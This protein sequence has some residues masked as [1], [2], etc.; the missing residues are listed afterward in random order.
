MKTITKIFA[1]LVLFLSCGKEASSVELKDG[2]V[3]MSDINSSIIF[4]MRYYSSHNF[5]G[6]TIDGYECAECILTT[7][8]AMA[9]DAIQ[10]ELLPFGLT[11]KIYDCYRPQRAVDHFV[12]WAK[13]LND[14]KMKKEFYP[15]VDKSNLFKDGYI[16][17]KSSHSR[18]STVD[19][20]IV[21]IPVPEQ[22]EYIDGMELVECYKPYDIRFGDNTIDMGTGFDCFGDYSHPVN[23]EQD[24][25]VRINRLLLRTL[26]LKHGFVPY[27]FEWWHFTYKNEPYPDTY[28]DFPVSR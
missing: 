11:L 5:I 14:D 10:K 24:L 16:A 18:G 23:A 8:A 13:D 22:E 7:E 3:Y 9:V 12:R 26:M 2:F 25:Q 27:E 4:D 1:L 28:F 21:P 20:T 17:A 19:L 6:G 15:D